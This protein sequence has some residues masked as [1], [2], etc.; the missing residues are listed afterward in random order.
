MK[1]LRYK[2]KSIGSFSSLAKTLGFSEEK[3]IHVAGNA[4]NYYIPNKPKTKS[5]GKKRQTYKVNEPLHKIQDAILEKIISGVEFPRYLQGSIKDIELPRDYVRDAALHATNKVLLKEDISSFF[6]S[7][8]AGLVHNMWKYFF[9]FPDAV[10]D[11]LTQLTTYDNFIPEGASTSPAVANLVFWKHEP[12]LEHELQQKGYLYTRYV[13][14]ISISFKARVSKDELQNITTKIYGMFSACGLKPNRDKDEN[15]FLR[16]RTVRS[17][18]KPMVVHGLNINSGK[19][20]L[21]KEERYKIRAAVKEL[22]LLVL[23]SAPQ[24]EISEKYDSVV[25]RVN[26][27]KRLHPNEADKYEA[28]LNEIRKAIDTT[29]IRN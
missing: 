22:E 19:P 17:R 6:S 11:I 4:S 21:P 8:R 18:N 2:Y 1:Q 3:L 20:T 25:G 9:K 7:T 28:R 29:S 23:S 14:D 5:N 10:A 24:D 12:A 27:M 16:K 15:G 13:D 26:T